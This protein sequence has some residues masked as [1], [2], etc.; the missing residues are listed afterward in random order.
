MNNNN[1]NNVAHK[2]VANEQPKQRRNISVGNRA[3]A[4][5]A[6]NHARENARTEKHAALHQITK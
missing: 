3:F 1:N 2:T 5:N 4:T 6:C